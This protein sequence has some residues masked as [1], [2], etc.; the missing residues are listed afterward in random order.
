[1]KHKITCTSNRRIFNELDIRDDNVTDYEPMYYDL[2]CRIKK[3]VGDM[4]EIELHADAGS[5]SIV[6][7][8]GVSQSMNILFS[9]IP[10]AFEDE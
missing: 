3:V 6:K 1:M 9:Y 5:V 4:K 10:E 7:A 8:L 2:V